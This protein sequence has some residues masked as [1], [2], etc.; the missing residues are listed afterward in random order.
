M[1]S[2]L[3]Q[4]PNPKISPPPQKIVFFLAKMEKTDERCGSDSYAKTSEWRAEVWRKCHL[5]MSLPFFPPFK[6]T[7]NGLLVSVS[8]AGYNHATQLKKCLTKK[9]QD[10]YLKYWTTTVL[11][12]IQCFSPF[13]ATE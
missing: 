2:S 1:Q 10:I 5:S 11:P 6:F 9:S 4:D 7:Q 13:P 8:A 12:K 3:S